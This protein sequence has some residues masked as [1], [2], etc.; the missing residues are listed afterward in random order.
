VDGKVQIW[1]P[2]TWKPVYNLKVKDTIRGVQFMHN[3]TFAIWGHNRVGLFTINT[4]LREFYTANSSSRLATLI[5]EL[6]SVMISFEVGLPGQ[7]QLAE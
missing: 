1:D 5:P 6:G 3:D 7:T 2:D 4:T